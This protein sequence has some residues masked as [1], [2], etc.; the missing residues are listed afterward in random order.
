MQI[1]FSIPDEEIRKM[2]KENKERDIEQAK[3]YREIFSNLIPG[4]DIQI[5]GLEDLESK[6]LEEY[7]KEIR[8]QLSRLFP[9]VDHNE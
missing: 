6:P 1:V 7:E 2:A 9:D 4:A 5:T 3:Q 8:E